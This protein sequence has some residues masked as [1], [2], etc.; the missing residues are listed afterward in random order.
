MRA[1]GFTPVSVFFLDNY[2]R[3]RPPLKNREALLVVHLMRHK[4]DTR[5]PF[6]SV[7]S[8]AVKMGI[9]MTAVRSH[10][11]NLE[12][13][14]YLKREARRATTNV[15]HLDGLFDRLETLIA[16]E[17]KTLAD[18]LSPAALA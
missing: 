18:V 8:L 3:L 4:Y 15:F 12:L 5:S 6:P 7:K 17:E 14:G 13:K 1:G 2:H 16:A 9:S 10:L 11:R